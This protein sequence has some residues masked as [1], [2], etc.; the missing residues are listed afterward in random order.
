MSPLA[1][2]YWKVLYEKNEQ[3]D[4]WKK[5]EHTKTLQISS[6]SKKYSEIR[7]KTFLTEDEFFA[8]LL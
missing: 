4:Q 3:A 2:G 6:K 8:E 7:K 1:P 5:L